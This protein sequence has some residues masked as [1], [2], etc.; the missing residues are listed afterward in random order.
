MKK[1]A[2]IGGGVAGLSAALYALRANAEVTLFDQ[3]GLGGL[4]ATIGKVENYP[5]YNE[6]DG[7]EL[8]DKMARQVKALGL[9][10]VKAKVLSLTK[11]GQDF[12]IDTN[13]GQFLFPAVVVAT[14]TSHNK[15][16]I[17]EDYVGKGVSYCATCDGN[18]YRN[19]PVAV[20]GNGGIAV[21]EAMYLADLC[22]K[23]YVVCSAE[24][25]QAEERAVQNLLAKSNVELLVSAHVSALFGKDVLEGV[26][27]FQQGKTMDL[28][29][30]GLFV[31]TGAKPVSDF[32][33]IPE[34][35]TKNGYIVVD[36]RCQTSVK[37]LFSAGD[38]T[39]GMLKQIVTACGDGAKAG[40]FASAFSA[41]IKR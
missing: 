26:Q 23:V 4:V 6:I 28:H 30:D 38:V 16:G 12:V 19:S 21:N 20:V 15:L 13:K 35:A 14:G 25:L 9:Q 29:V 32:V 5:S 27:V 22:S 37:G 24:S 18:F 1:I 40:T 3:F 10:F 17:E 31:A 33:N 2:I 34:V 36:E 39:S 8:A 41:T 11:Q 7:W